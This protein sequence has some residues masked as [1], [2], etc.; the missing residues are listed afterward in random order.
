MPINKL[1]ITIPVLNGGQTF[2]ET[3]EAIAQQRNAAR[4]EVELL[5]IDSGSTDGSVELARAA[6]ARVI[7]IDKSDFQHGG[8]RNMAISE[9]TGD[10]VAL[11]TDDS[12]PADDG[13]LDA[14]VEG[15]GQADDVALVFGPQLP[16][17]EHSH[18]VRREM[19]EH[20]KT[21]GDGERI[22]VQRVGDDNASEYEI[23]Q[24]KFTF[25]S[26][27]NGAVARWAWEKIPYRNVAYAE[28][29]LIGRE[30][31]EAGYAKV[32]HPG[33]AV[34]HSHDY[35]TWKFF[36]RHFDEYRAMLEVAGYRAPVGIRSGTRTVIG[37][38]RSDR[39]FL[40]EESV[41]GRALL[42]AT[43]D[44]VLHHSLRV[45]GE[46]LGGRADKLPTGLSKHLSLEGRGGYKP[47]PKSDETS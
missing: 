14:I 40:R 7:E 16:R 32:F 13:W 11:L 45:L 9:A 26:D 44:S 36:Q 38:T 46:W 24:G 34:L 3:L 12:M 4:V 18:T 2:G 20:F 15:F 31:I 25:F 17:P 47:A 8:T 6:G 29:Q 5:V 33:A 43:V 41:G 23:N 22:D 10:V 35:S 19:H 28:D 42:A 39:A 30:M 21:W 1:T 27:A 37:L